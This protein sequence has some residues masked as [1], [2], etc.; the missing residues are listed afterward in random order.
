MT[1]WTYSPNARRIEQVI[2]IQ[3]TLTTDANAG[4]REVVITMDDAT[5]ELW[6]VGS[7]QVTTA[8]E[9]QVWQYIENV[10]LFSSNDVVYSFWPT[11]LILPLTA[12]LA[13]DVQNFQAGDTLTDIRIVLATWVRT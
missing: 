8:N 12:V 11:T 1:N 10:G 6:R 7:N 5:S 13:S 9:T 2:S 3:C 4:N